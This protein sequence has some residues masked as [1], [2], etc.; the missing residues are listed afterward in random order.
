MKWGF[1]GPCTQPDTGT[2]TGP[3]GETCWGFTFR[4]SPV[5]HSCYLEFP[6]TNSKLLW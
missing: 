5:L 1:V 4:G 6:V 2:E 3:G